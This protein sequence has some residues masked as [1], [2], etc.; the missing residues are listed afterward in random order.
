MQSE[1]A[2][3]FRAA[4]SKEIANFKEEKYLILF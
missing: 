4:M 1:D 2:N 3:E